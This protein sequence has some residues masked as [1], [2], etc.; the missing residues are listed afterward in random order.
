MRL[1][2]R[3]EQRANATEQSQLETD[4][5][6]ARLLE[7]E[8]SWTTAMA[9]YALSGGCIF[10]SKYVGGKTLSA[11]ALD[12][13]VRHDPQSLVP[14]QK[15]IL[16][17]PSKADGIAKTITCVQAVWFCSQ[18]FWR[19][20]QGM[21]TSLL[22]LNTW[23]HCVCALFIY[24]F[25][26]HKPYDVLSHV[27]IESCALEHALLIGRARTASAQ[28]P[29]RDILR[30]CFISIEEPGQ[31]GV[32]VRLLEALA[33]TTEQNCPHSADR[34]GDLQIV[35]QG[36][37]LPGTGFVLSDDDES[38]SPI[39]VLT[40]LLHQC[41]QL[42][43]LRVDSQFC[44]L[45]KDLLLLAKN[46]SQWYPHRIRN[47]DFDGILGY[48]S[49]SDFGATVPF[50]MALIFVLYGGLHLFAWSYQF[51]SEKESLLWKLS[52]VST[53]SSGLI[54]LLLF[55]TDNSDQRSE[56]GTQTSMT[57]SVLACLLGTVLLICFNFAGRTYLVIESFIAL[58]N[59]PPSVYDMPVWTAYFPHI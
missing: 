28:Q 23:A 8:P 36:K 50:V 13:L 10:K 15:A 34:H 47:V 27:L 18:C 3:T 49:T 54:M 40:H 57:N 19:V 37:S 55:L 42:W 29:W 53:A 4:R 41:Q 22:E 21:A 43:K 16:Q 46:N 26:W 12:Y 31:N 9:F 45:P 52:S 25:W 51:R 5:V 7:D 2:N 33:W 20:G 11:E 39:Y 56:P 35:E 6:I 30:R 17:E 32:R 58:P 24:F 1:F 48:T 14:L 44:E 59:S 38:L